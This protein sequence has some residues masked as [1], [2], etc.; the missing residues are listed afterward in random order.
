[1]TE[2]PFAERTAPKADIAEILR[3]HKQWWESNIGWDIDRMVEVFPSPGHEYLM[4]NFNGHPYFDMTE[5]VALWKW[6]REIIAQTGGL[7]TEIMRLEVRADTAW[8]ACEF[9]IEAEMLDGGEW[10]ADSVDATIGRATE[11]YHRDDGTGA[12][13]WRMWHTHITALPDPDETRPGFADST[14]SRG[15][16]RVP[17][18]PLPKGI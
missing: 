4:F 16:G 5:K 1:M 13:R 14:N 11:I 8:L 18:N 15:L 6:Y 9:T 12:P 17:W 7:R 2:T 3:L 10:T